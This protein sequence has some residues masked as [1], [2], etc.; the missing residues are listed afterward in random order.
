[1]DRFPETTIIRQYLLG[2]LRERQQLEESL[3]EEMLF[4]DELSEIVDSVEDEMIEEYLDGS[5]DVVDK[6]SFEHFFLR[7][8][9]RRKKLEFAQLLR[10]HFGNHQ[11]PVLPAQ[12]FEGRLEH[13]GRELRVPPIPTPSFWHQHARTLMEIS[14]LLVLSALS[15]LY[16][17]MMK[18]KIAESASDK[19]KLGNELTQER[20]HSATLST[21]LDAALHPSA[22]TLIPE[23]AVPKFRSAESG[24]TPKFSPGA[25]Q[26][27][28]FL[29]P[30]VA[31]LRAGTQLINVDLILKAIT[32]VAY[33]VGLENR[34]GERIW[35]TRVYPV[36]ESS[37]PSSVT[38]A[39]LRFALPAAGMEDGEYSFAVSSATRSTATPD[40]YRFAVLKVK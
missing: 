33:N 29:P 27:L 22:L 4:N 31:R 8:Q 28:T 19:A 10:E 3:S 2:Q 7:P 14:A 30:Q 20:E 40:R 36:M 11:E 9:E 32:P 12:Y 18:G 37:A 23:T 35:S 25:Q 39:H 1:M 13:E 17:M 21:Q 34:E 26:A 24:E 5:M 15:F 16:F 38:T 6:R